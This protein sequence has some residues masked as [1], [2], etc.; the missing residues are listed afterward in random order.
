MLLARVPEVYLIVSHYSHR[1]GQKGSLKAQG[2]SLLD[3]SE[4]E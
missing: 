1:F 3:I 4:Q 2:R